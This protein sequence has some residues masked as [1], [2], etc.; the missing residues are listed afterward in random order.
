[1]K[2]TPKWVI[3]VA[4]VGLVTALLSWNQHGGDSRQAG[5]TYFK[6][7]TTESEDEANLTALVGD[8]NWFGSP[9]GSNELAPLQ[10]TYLFKKFRAII[11]MC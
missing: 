7:A 4:I 5:P 2:K 3:S 1:M 10:K 11:V 8:D 9:S 6:N